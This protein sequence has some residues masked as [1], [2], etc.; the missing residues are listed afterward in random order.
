MRPDTDFPAETMPL[1]NMDKII[2]ASVKIKDCTLTVFHI[3]I[4]IIAK[5]VNLI[6]F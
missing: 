2:E 5:V 6:E 4:S 3:Y 1:K